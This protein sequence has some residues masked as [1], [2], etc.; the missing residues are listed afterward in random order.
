GADVV[1][2]H[3][4]AQ[5]DVD[6]LRGYA[7]DIGQHLIAL[8]QRDDRRCV[9]RFELR[10]HGPINHCPAIDLA[11]PTALPPGDVVRKALAAML[12]RGEIR[13]TARLATLIAQV[14]RSASLPERPADMAARVRDRPGLGSQWIRGH[15][16]SSPRI[17]TVVNKA[18][19][20]P[21]LHNAICA[22]G[23]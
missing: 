22:S 14:P 2:L 4:D 3:P 20:P 8:V 16:G 9:R 10:R 23:T 6:V 12:G 18:P 1:E 19:A 21:L 15:R 11:A 13:E 7:D 17:S 5:A